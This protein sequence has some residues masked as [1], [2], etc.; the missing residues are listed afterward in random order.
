MTLETG[1]EWEIAVGG[2]LVL[3]DRAIQMAIRVRCMCNSVAVCADWAAP[4]RSECAFLDESSQDTSLAP[5]V[6]RIRGAVNKLSTPCPGCLAMLRSAG[7]RP[8]HRLTRSFGHRDQ[9]EPNSF[10]RSPM[11]TRLP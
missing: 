10:A 1:T 6:F 11:Q 3:S 8:F 4:L 9:E 7:F 5:P 2:T